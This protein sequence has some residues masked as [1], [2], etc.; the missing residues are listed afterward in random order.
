MELIS[1]RA[2]EYDFVLIILKTVF[3]AQLL[4]MES[5]WRKRLRKGSMSA[6][7]SRGQTGQKTKKDKIPKI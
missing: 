6:P 2:H 7:D 4:N 5:K 1:N 3:N